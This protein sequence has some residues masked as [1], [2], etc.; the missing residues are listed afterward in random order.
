MKLDFWEALPDD[1]QA[2]FE[3]ARHEASWRFAKQT[4]AEWAKVKTMLV[5]EHGFTVCTLPEEDVAR[6]IEAAV[7]VWDYIAAKDT[8][9]A[10]SVQMMKDYLGR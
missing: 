2:L 6:L 9:C 10:K 4:Y 1:I 7:E 3:L 8:Y 5:E